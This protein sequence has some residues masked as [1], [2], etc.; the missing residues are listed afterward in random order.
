MRWPARATSVGGIVCAGSVLGGTGRPHAD[1][2]RPPRPDLHLHRPVPHRRGKRSARLQRRVDHRQ[3]WCR[4]RSHDVR[5]RLHGRACASRSVVPTASSTGFVSRR[6]GFRAL[7][8][9]HEYDHH[10]SDVLI[11][12]SQVSNSRGVGIFVDGYVSKVTIVGVTVTNA[13]SSGIYLEAGSRNN[14]VVGNT[15]RDS[16]YIENGPNGQ[17]FTLAGNQFRYWGSG[18]RGPVDRRVRTTTSCS[19]NT[20]TRTPPAAIFLYT[21]CGEFVN[22]R[23][24]R[25]LPAAHQGREQ[26]DPGQP[27]RRWPERRLGRLADERQ[28]VSD[29]L[30]Q[31]A[32]PQRAARAHHPRLR[33]EQRDPRQHV[34]RRRARDTRRG[35]RHADRSAT[36]SM[37]RMR[38]I[39][40]SSS[41]RS[42]AAP[43]W[44]VR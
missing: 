26:R 31:H 35:R 5:R 38:A 22:T 10:L 18:S 1:R 43:S 34:H 13:G 4:H 36:P 29:G 8:A 24:E 9:G 7:T 39:T 42:G 21:N 17:L 33:P 23:P 32:L 37:V 19:N 14:A 15:I 41:A 16:G 2:E 11:E 27:V 6:A 25:V 40:P 20:F 30:Q 28:H 3:R 44:A 12:K